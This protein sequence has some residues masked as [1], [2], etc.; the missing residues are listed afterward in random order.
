MR[1]GPGTERHKVTAIRDALRCERPV[2]VCITNYKKGGRKFYNQ[3]YVAP[4]HDSHGRVSNYI[5]IQTDVTGMVKSS[6]GGGGRASLNLPQPAAEEV[7][8]QLALPPQP[9][10]DAPQVRCA[11]HA[12]H[13]YICQRAVLRCD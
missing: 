5:G 2:Q 13:S 9:P 7:G 6:R 4:I 12:P 10:P 11:W 1:A 8:G 3:L